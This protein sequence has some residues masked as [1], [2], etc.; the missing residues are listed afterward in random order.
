MIKDTPVFILNRSPE[1]YEDEQYNE[2][3]EFGER[4]K[5]PD[6]IAKIDG[7]C[8]SNQ[9]RFV[10]YPTRGRYR[11][12]DVFSLPQSYFDYP[13]GTKNYNNRIHILIYL[14][15][16]ERMWRTFVETFLDMV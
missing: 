7:C 2:T 8:N 6:G 3:N 9:Q 14:K 4:K 11:D 5:Y 13:K 15:K 10:L 1:Q 12:L 16:P